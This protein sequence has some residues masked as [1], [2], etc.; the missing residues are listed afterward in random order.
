MLPEIGILHQLAANN[1]FEVT[2]PTQGD[3]KAWLANG[4][5]LL[6]SPLASNTSSRATDFKLFFQ[7]SDFYY[8][9]M[10]NECN[11]FSQ[12][13]IETMWSI[14]EVSRLPKS[15]GWST[16]KMYYSAFFAAHSL[17]RIYGKACSQLSAQHVAKVYEIAAAT[18]YAGNVTSI[19]SGFYLSSVDNGEVTYR[20][21]K[22]SHAD[23]WSSFFDLL[24]WIIQEIDG[25]TGRGV[26]KAD[27]MTLVSNIKLA[28]SRSGASRGNWMSQMRNKINYQHTSGV[29]YPYVGA[30]HENRMISKNAG[31]LQAPTTF[32]LRENQGDVSAMYNISNAILSLMYQLVKYG[33]ERSGKASTPLKNGTFRLLH[34]IQMI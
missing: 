3:L 29:W 6:A 8:A 17:L 2:N 13:A 26:H 15:A 11:R 20:K 25:T 24:A 16:I 18:S 28:I 32:D 1:V 22:D 23:T 4:Q 19:D 21:L 14:G 33:F 30:I 10:A 27:A 31:W 34:Q 5:Y 9:S 7:R 12:A